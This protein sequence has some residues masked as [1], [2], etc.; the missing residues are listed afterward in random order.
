[1]PRFST[2]RIILYH[3]IIDETLKRPLE[4]MQI[5]GLSANFPFA[6]LFIYAYMQSWRLLISGLQYGTTII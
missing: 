2:R 3:F 4:D 5:S 1:M 6:H